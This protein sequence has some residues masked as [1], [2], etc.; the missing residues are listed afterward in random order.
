MCDSSVGKCHWPSVW[1]ALVAVA[2]GPIC[3]QPNGSA[4]PVLRVEM[5][6]QVQVQA[7]QVTL[8]DIAY[9]GSFDP[10]V[11]RRAMALPLGQAPRSGETASLQRDQVQRWLRSQTGLQAE[12]I[13]W[14]GSSVTE[15]SVASHPMAGEEV[16]FAAE[17]A[18]RKHLENSVSLS[19]TVATKIDLQAVSMPTTFNM[20]EGESVL[21]ARPLGSTPITK[22]MLVWIDVFAAGR[23]VR[24]TPVRFEVTVFA[25]ATVAAGTLAAETLLSRDHLEVREVDLTRFDLRRTGSG[26]GAIASGAPAQPTQRLRR[27]IQS[28]EPITDADVQPLPAVSRGDWALLT[29]QNGLVALE[30]RVEVLQDGRIGQSVRVKQVNA[31]SAVLARVSGPGR[32]EMQP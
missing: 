19:G 31:T 26:A 30:S 4:P 2:T 6:P 29:T 28:G 24:A 23:F 9:L 22:H 18:L 17:A 8:T 32:L 12:E 20:P 11:L 5:R 25:R 15:I 10:G 1:L 16:V 7:S 21:R 3:A 13:Q 27:P 14:A